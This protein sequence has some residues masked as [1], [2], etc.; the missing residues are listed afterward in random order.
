MTRLGIIGGIGPETS[1][2]FCLNVNN[3]V[4]R[5]TNVQPS[6]IMENVPMPEST[7]NKLAHGEKPQLVLELLSQSVNTLNSIKSDVIAIPCNTVHVFIDQLRAI[8]KVPIVSIIEESAKECEKRNFK[9]VGLISSTTSVREGLHSKELEKRNISCLIPTDKQQDKI[10]E[11]IVK[12]I[13]NVKE[14]NDV[15]K[16]RSIISDLK[17]KG[18]D[19]IMLACTDIRTIISEAD[20]S[21][22][23]VETTT[24]LENAVVRLLVNRLFP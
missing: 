20:T 17:S 1:C 23:I 21:L 8:S 13:R 15:I 10:S 22:P 9:R 19:S 6:M 5:E 14:E 24:V 12:I 3:K 18:A 11:I 4:I 16:I 7:L 2:M